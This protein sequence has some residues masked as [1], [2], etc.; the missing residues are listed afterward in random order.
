MRGNINGMVVV[1][2]VHWDDDL[3]SL[4]THSF[5]SQLLYAILIVQINFFRRL[6]GTS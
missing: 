2:A 6:V 5:L 1:E 3:F 4:F